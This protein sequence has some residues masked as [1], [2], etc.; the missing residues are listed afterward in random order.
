MKIR[1]LLPSILFSSLLFGQG[2]PDFSSDPLEAK[3]I[4]DDVQ[5]FWNAFEKVGSDSVNPF[6]AYIDQGT[7]GLKGF[8]PYRIINADSLLI[9]VKSRKADYLASKMYFI[10]WP[11]RKNVFK[12]VM[13][14]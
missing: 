4:T 7:L 6:K 12:Q 3:F 5:H 9:M 13:R 11:R 8:I 14:P 1:A 2:N 10:I